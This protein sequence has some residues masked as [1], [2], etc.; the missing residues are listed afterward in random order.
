MRP[1]DPLDAGEPNQAVVGAHADGEVEQVLV[2]FGVLLN[3]LVPF[4]DLGK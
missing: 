1:L 4:F 2:F 3:R